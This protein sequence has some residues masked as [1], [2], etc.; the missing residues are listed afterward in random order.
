MEK[1]KKVP[2]LI[3]LGYASSSCRRI[4]LMN[5]SDATML[6]R[7]EVDPLLVVGSYGDGKALVWPSDIAPHW[8]TEPF[9]SWEGYAK[10]WN[11]ALG[12]LAT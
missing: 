7:V 5:K 8:C 12:W 10:L 6:A 4:L 2:G 3:A 11:Q 1:A 9:T